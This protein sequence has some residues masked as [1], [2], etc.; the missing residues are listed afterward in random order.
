MKLFY[1]KEFYLTN[2]V[3][4]WSIKLFLLLSWI[5]SN[6]CTISITRRNSKKRQ[7][8]NI[9]LSHLTICFP[10]LWFP[11]AA[12]CVQADGDPGGLHHGRTSHHHQGVHSYG[13]HIMFQLFKFSY[14]KYKKSFYFQRQISIMTS[15][16][17]FMLIFI[18]PL[19]L[20]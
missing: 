17:I 4:W 13:K 11:A 18:S 2:G 15:C 19:A 12:V 14:G 9:T 3:I 8:L 16:S 1:I 10:F 5:I 6:D 7:H 20:K